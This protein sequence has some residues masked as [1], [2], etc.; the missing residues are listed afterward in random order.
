MNHSNVR[1]VSNQP[2]AGL[3]C[4]LVSWLSGAGCAQTPTPPPAYPPAQAALCKHVGLESV[5]TPQHENRDAT[6][7]VAVYTFNEPNVPPAKEPLRF[8][9]R[10]DRSRVQEPQKNLEK[11][12]DIVC[13]PETEAGQP[14]QRATLPES[15]TAPP[16]PHTAEASVTP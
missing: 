12:P 16:E 4:V 5:E 2:T 15:T 11:R 7:L 10:V 14:L 9:A 13:S 8:T 3:F 6:S 1:S